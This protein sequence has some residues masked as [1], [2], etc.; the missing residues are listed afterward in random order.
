M[1]FSWNNKNIFRAPVW[2][3]TEA[4][5][6]SLTSIFLLS[7]IKN[8]P[9]AHVRQI[10]PNIYA[11]SALEM[12][13]QSQAVVVP[14]AL[15][16]QFWTTSDL[17]KKIKKIIT[18]LNLHHPRAIASAAQSIHRLI[19]RQNLP[20]TWMTEL[21]SALKK[22]IQ[23]NTKHFQI[24]LYFGS[25]EIGQ[26]EWLPECVGAAQ[27]NAV[28]KNIKIALATLYNERFI[29]ERLQRGWSQ[30]RLPLTIVITALETVSAVE[31]ITIRTAHPAYTN[32]AL[33]QVIIAKKDQA[34]D[35]LIFKPAL[36]TKK[37]LVINQATDNG[38]AI[39]TMVR[40]ALDPL[41][42]LEQKNKQ[43]VCLSGWLNSK[44]GVVTITQ[45][46][47]DVAK[48]K[49]K[50][51]EY[52]LSHQGTVLGSG[53]FFGQGIAVGAV[54]LLRTAS[55]TKSIGSGSIIVAKNLLSIPANS[56]A[57]AA[58]CILEENADTARVTAKI[59]QINLPI[60]AGVKGATKKFRTGTMV[61]VANVNN[62]GLVYSGALPYEVKPV[63]RTTQN[64]KTEIRAT[65]AHISIDELIGLSG[66]HHP[67][68]YFNK[69]NNSA[70]YIE[71]ISQALAVAVAQHYPVRTTVVFSNSLPRVFVQWAG[72]KQS[73][74][75]L[76]LRP[77]ARGAERYLTKQY[78]AVLAAECLAL[79]Q[80]REQFGFS[81]IDVQLPYCRSAVELEEIMVLLKANG[82]TRENGWRFSLATDAPGH[83][84]LT[85]A[86]AKHLDELVFDVDSLVKSTT[87][88]RTTSIS[89][90]GQKTIEHALSAIA[91]AARKEKARIALSGALLATEP[92]L[93]WS[94]V[95]SGIKTLVVAPEEESMVRSIACEAENAVG[96]AG[97]RPQFLRTMAGVACLGALIITVGAGCGAQQ[98]IANTPQLT[99][100]EIRAGIMA[101]LAEE[102]EAIKSEQTITTVK[103]FADFRVVHPRRYEATF[104]PKDLILTNRDTGDMVKFSVVSKFSSAS[105]T[106]FLTTSK[107]SGKTIMTEPEAVD[108]PKISEVELVKNKI[109]RV[110][111]TVSSDE[112]MAMIASIQVI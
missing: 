25:T 108:S 102:R 56:L 66:A 54:S 68:T 98:K 7:D 16:Q 97:V 52:V 64:S 61:T 23:K 6:S 51:Y 94:A 30:Q 31:R 101:E 38:G 73:E 43:P 22:I 36:N 49:E 46:Y 1:K 103:G 81:Q 84:I 71:K 100:A 20:D 2:L 50:L 77:N 90:I 19:V 72:G 17:D 76:R 104:S 88:A 39:E 41:V 63:V 33:A 79:K 107:L 14:N 28:C 95:K 112:I 26:A 21:R 59:H 53:E 42:N 4:S 80:V 40:T 67:L 55:T 111:S 8:L 60:L 48:N 62:E 29:R 45:L 69:K 65:H 3:Q 58:G 93:V 24:T 89:P 78:Q 34:V 15:V 70:Q 74:Q 35:Y 13:F 37:R 11:L 96:Y 18:P 27:E 44:T 99:P 92:R 57:E 9:A 32:S 10:P 12:P 109:L 86:L 82:L 110:E 106:D 105:S 75:A 83:A 87:G 5:S 91:K 85:T 47:F